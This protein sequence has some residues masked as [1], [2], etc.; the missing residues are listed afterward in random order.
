MT[1]SLIIAENVSKSFGL[2]FALRGVSFTIGRGELIA[3]LGANGSGKTTL[4]RTLSGL[5]KHS[6]GKVTIGGW[7][8]PREAAAIRGQIGVV[9]HLPLLYDDLTAEENLLLYAEL[10]NLPREM[11]KHGVQ[12]RIAESLA[13]VGLA[14]RSKDRVRTFSR[15]MQQRLSLARAALHQPAIML[16]DEPYTGLDAPGAA[17]LD[18]LLREWREAGTTLIAALHDLERAAAVCQRA[19]ILAGGKLAADVPMPPAAELIALFNQ[20]TP[21]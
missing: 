19:L 13:R 3:L 21:S 1:D 4:L 17:L 10:Y 2:R 14:K 7:D 16:L 15:G 20:H 18:S 11:G 12:A 8:L 5:S 6:S 9:A